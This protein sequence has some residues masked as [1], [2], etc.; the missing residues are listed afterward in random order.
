[1]TDRPNIVYVFADQMRAMSVG[2]LH[3]D[4]V[5]TPNVDRLASQ[6]VLFTNA[7]AN[8]P[9]CTPSRASLI[10]GKHALSCRTIA[11]DL[12]LPADEPGIA[13]VLKEHGYRRG[14]IGKWHLDGISRHMFTPPGRRRH[15]FDDYWAVYNCNHNYF[16][17]KWF[18]DDSPELRRRPGYDADIQTDQAIAFLERFREEPFCLYLSWGPPHNPYRVVPQE[19][20]DMYPPDEIP[21][22]PNVE[23]PDRAAIAGY[24]AHVSALDR[25][26]GRLMETLDHLGLTENTIVVFSSDHGDMLWSRGRLNK[27]Q[28]YDESIRIPLIIRWPGHLPAGVVDDL[29]IG[30]VDHA[31]TLLGLADVDV[32][33]GMNGLDLSSAIR[34]TSDG[35]PSSALI[36]EYVSFDQARDWQPWRGVRTERY[37]Y[38]RWLQG[39]ALLYDNREDPYQ[40]RNL[41]LEPGHDSLAR[42]LEGELRRWLTR[43]DDQFTAG[44]EHLREL[45]R[46]EEWLIRQEHFYG[47]GTRNF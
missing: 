36:A 1:M 22:R 14:Y 3:D 45:G 19:F 32:P 5:Q 46:W 33:A 26:V 28:P 21:L 23:G 15:G 29:L 10:T 18:E 8:T 44:E 38:V 43:L 35:R 12:R 24:Y 37:T 34:G 27:Q 16:D 2:C 13:D 4:P 6:G 7:V 39:G 47:F 40:L 11:N 41:M 20:L 25:N 31:P 17:C 9:V 42:D 30:V